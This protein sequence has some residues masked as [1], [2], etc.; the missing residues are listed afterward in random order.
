MQLLLLILQKAIYF[1]TKIAS[2]EDKLFYDHHLPL[3]SMNPCKN[4][5]Q[6]LVV[7]LVTTMEKLVFFLIMIFPKAISEDKY[8]GKGR[9]IVWLYGNSPTPKPL[10]VYE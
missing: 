3:Q 8:R 1:V 10:P 6:K 9:S 2:A 5:V 4:F 7:Q